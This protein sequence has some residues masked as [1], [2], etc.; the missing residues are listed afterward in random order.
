[1]QRR[2]ARGQ[3]GS[4]GRGGDVAQCV[5]LAAALSKFGEEDAWRS[6]V[7]NLILVVGAYRTQNSATQM[8]TAPE[9]A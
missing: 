6:A 7:A 9:G 5:V 2:T 3:V 4:A 1:M 8:R